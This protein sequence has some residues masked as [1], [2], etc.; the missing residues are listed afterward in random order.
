M[1]KRS[2][3]KGEAYIGAAVPNELAEKLEAMA[4]RTHRSV[5]DI[6]RLLI[7]SAAVAEVPDI[8]MTSLVG[9]TDGG[10]S[11]RRQP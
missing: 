6:L 3:I 9:A 8:Q 2:V 7:A 11:E 10:L 1:A 4:M 5:S